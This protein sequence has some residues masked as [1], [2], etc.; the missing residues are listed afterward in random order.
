MSEEAKKTEQKKRLEIGV[1]CIFRDGKVLIQTRP[2]GKSFAGKWEFP[3][4]KIEEGERAR[5][6]V[7]REIMEELGGE[8][9]VKDMFF[10]DTHNFDTTILVLLFY[11]CTPKKDAKFVPQENQE[12]KWVESKDFAGIKFLPTN[13]R[14]LKKLKELPEL[15][16][17]T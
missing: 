11:R 5:D 6:C 17:S 3:G 2:K 10:K 12:I 13:Y 14:I 9:V 1:A 15:T 7:S 8:I 4:G 16:Q